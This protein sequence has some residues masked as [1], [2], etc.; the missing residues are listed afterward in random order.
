LELK[1]GNCF[2]EESLSIKEFNKRKEK[3]RK[4]KKR[5]IYAAG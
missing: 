2:L 3:K 1:R 5:K 4:E